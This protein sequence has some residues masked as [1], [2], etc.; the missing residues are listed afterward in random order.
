MYRRIITTDERGCVSNPSNE[1]SKYVYPALTTGAI[2]SNQDVCYNV[3]PGV[4]GETIAPTGG[5]SYPN[6]S[7][8]W[9]SSNDNTNLEPR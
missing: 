1:V 9:Y 7:Y 8:Q 6:Y 5:S 2:G 4:I 3:S